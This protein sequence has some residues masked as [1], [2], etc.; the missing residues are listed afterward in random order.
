[1]IKLKLS[2]A[3]LLVT[4]IGLGSVSGHAAAGA[5]YTMSNSSTANAI[6]R[7]NRSAGGQ[8]SPAGIFPTG[9][10]GTGGGLGNQGGLAIDDEKG[11]LFAVNAGSNTSRFSGLL[12]T[13]F[14]LKIRSIAVKCSSCLRVNFF[15]TT[16]SPT[17]LS[18]TR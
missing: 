18:P 7:F 4:V 8:L 5:V 15:R 2:V 11:L 10:R 13:G 1:M 9:G 3:L 14:N 12:R 16:T 17:G 6:L